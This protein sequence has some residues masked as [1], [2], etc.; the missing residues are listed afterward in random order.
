MLDLWSEVAV[1]CKRCAEK[2]KG[3]GRPDAESNNHVKRIAEPSLQSGIHL[4]HEECIG[5]NTSRYG[6]IA[7]ALRPICFVEEDAANRNLNSLRFEKHSNCLLWRSAKAQI[8]CECVGCAQ[9]NDA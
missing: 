7:P 6:E 1:D 4:R 3:I 5:A 9:G 2:W 8:L